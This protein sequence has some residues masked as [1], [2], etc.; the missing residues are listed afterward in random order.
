MLVTLVLLNKSLCML[1]DM[2]SNILAVRC[3]NLKS[4][5]QILCELLAK[6][7]FYH[8]LISCER[9]GQN[10]GQ[11]PCYSFRVIKFKL[12]LSIPCTCYVHKCSAKLKLKCSTFV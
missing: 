7:T 4:I 2:R 10:L 5:D 6:N 3:A 11:I 8:H 9:M 1:Y 12:G